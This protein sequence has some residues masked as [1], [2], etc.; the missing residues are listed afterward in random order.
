MGSNK[1]IQLCMSQLKA[2]D[3]LWPAVAFIALWL[4]ALTFYIIKTVGHF[5]KLTKGVTGSNLN[6][7]LESIFAK[8]KMNSKQISDISEQLVQYENLAKG[9]FQ[10][11][12]FI[13]FNPFE[14]A[15]GDQSF[16]IALLDGEN[17]GVVISSLHARGGTRVYA[18]G[19]LGAK[20]ASHQ[21]SKEEKEAVEKA[22]RHVHV[23]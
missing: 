5:R 20:P 19:V 16:V 15:G 9:Y 8:Q 23:N 13:R 1:F 2:L 12:A 3:Y 6:Q 11:H 4:V 17:N 21:F 18:K 22:A 14:D 10:K 7:I